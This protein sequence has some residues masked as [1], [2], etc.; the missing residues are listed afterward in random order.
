MLRP[1]PPGAI[2]LEKI[3][4]FLRDQSVAMR[5]ILDQTTLAPSLLL[6]REAQMLL[7]L[8]QSSLPAV[9]EETLVSSFVHTPRAPDLKDRA[10]IFISDSFVTE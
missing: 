6:L 10:L 3:S 8:L 2:Y 9:K 4:D 7:Q 5:S 1:P